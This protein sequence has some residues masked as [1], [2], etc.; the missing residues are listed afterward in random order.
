[1]TERALSDLIV[2]EFGNLVSAP[3]CGKL[4]ADLGAEVI[5]IEEPGVGDKSRSRGPFAQDTPGLE[6]SGLFAYLNTNKLSITLKPNT[7]LGKKI[8]KELVKDSDIL[9]ENQPPSLME[10]LGLTY[11]TLEKVN[12]RLIMTSITPFGQTGPH[13]DYKAYE[14]NTYNGCGYGYVSTAC[15][16]E[17]V[18]PPVKAGGRQSEFGAAQSASVATMC[19]VYARDQI[20]AGQYIDISIQEIMAGQYESIVEHW[21][22]AENEMGGMTHPIIQPITP[23]ECKDGWIFL[24]CVEDD[25]F[26]RMVEI[27]GNPEWAENELFQDRFLRADYADALVPLLTEWT[28]QYTKDEIFKMCQEARVPVGPAYSSEDVVNSEHLNERNYFMEMDHP[29]MGRAK[30]PGAPYRLSVTPWQIKRHAP[31]LGEHNEEVFCH[32]LG[33]SKEDLVRMRQTGII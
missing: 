12:P 19:A 7:V 22:L 1:M 2:L 10:E 11:K 31:S 14:L 6:R 8:F 27:M 13:R 26:D 20:G 28:M 30:Y 18:M 23:L 9:V 32:R 33:Y 29:E 15:I 21:T 24:M 5:K 4:M 17:P 16:T 3:Y 25:Q